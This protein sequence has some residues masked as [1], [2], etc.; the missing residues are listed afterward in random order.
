LI[1]GRFI[2]SSAV[3]IAEGRATLG[4]HISELVS[5]LRAWRLWTRF[6][7][8]D[9]RARFRRSWVGPFWLVL[10]TAI[11]VGALGFVYG[12]L[13]QLEMRTFLPFV[14]VGLVIWGFISAV[15]SEGVMTFVE[16]ESFI[17][18]IRVSLFVYVMR[19][20]W[21]NTLV[22]AYQMV[23]ALAVVFALAAPDLWLLPLAAFGLLLVL[24][25]ATWIVPL[26]G[27]V[28]VRFRDLHPI[29]SNLLQ[30]MFF[31]TPILWSPSLLGERRWIAD[32]NPL[33]S[34]IS[35]VREPLMGMPPE[36]YAYVM[37]A[38]TT[39]CGFLTTTVL[40][41]RLSSRVVYWL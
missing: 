14:A 20:V 31:V 9:L 13:F 21:R 32:I 15:A 30:V 5:G 41:S 29:I 37:V 2:C 28:G 35:V 4:G 16:A 17:R 22:L 39:I 27:L 10:T 11:F 25:Q 34:L 24:L 19:V 40:F 3:R 38:G 26:L 33:H 18:Q 36:P 12:S 23:V 8:D 7:K 6:A 1:R